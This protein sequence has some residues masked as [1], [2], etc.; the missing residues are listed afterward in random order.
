MFVLARNWHR[1]VHHGVAMVLVLGLALATSSPAQALV[2]TPTFDSSITSDPNAAAIENTINQAISFYQSTYSNPVNVNIYFKEGGG[3]GQSNTLVYDI[4][5]SNFLNGLAANQSISHQSDQA[6]AL[7]NL[8]GGSINPVNGTTDLLVKSA[9]ARVLGIATSTLLNSS[10]AAGIGG[11]FIYDGII[12]LNTSLTTPGSPG[13]TLQYSLLATAEHEI[14]E[15]LGL[16]SSLPNNSNNAFFNNPSGEDLYRY[17]APGVRSF[18]A[19]SGANAY[20]SINGGATNLD[21]FNNTQNGGD[22]GDWQGGAQ[23]QVQD[24][25][26]TPGGSASLNASSVE[27]TALDVLGYDRSAV[28]ATPEPGTLLLFGQGAVAVVG[29]VWRKQRQRRV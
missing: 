27:L 1:S 12:S 25:F 19:T 24:A 17:S 11:G 9:D 7:A 4:G 5:Y 3:L 15:V 10:G 18:T 16:G 6:T 2:I 8:P 20:F 28:T 21:Q 22:Y 14:D 23:P 13:S 26:G 29:L